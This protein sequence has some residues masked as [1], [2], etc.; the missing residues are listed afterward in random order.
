[1]I[2]LFD[3]L[4]GKAISYSPIKTIATDFFNSID[5]KNSLKFSHIVIHHSATKDGLANDWDAIR[6]WHI[7]KIGSPDP[8]SS[9]YN[10]YA[11][12]PMIDIGYYFG[13]E[14]DDNKYVYR[15][16]RSLSWTGG[17][18][19]GFNGKPNA[20][21]GV[22]CIGNFDSNSLNL[23]QVGMISAL[24]YEICHYYKIPFSNI[25]GHWQSFIILKQVKTKEEA[26]TKYKSCPGKNFDVELIRNEVK[27][28]SYGKTS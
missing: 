4:F 2:Y 1:M 24:C 16:G 25:I 11:A 27:K 21:L 12:A 23:N 8:K 5:K 20:G 15:T 7:G 9:D 22:C 19:L 28:L 6:K 10:K 3:R 26:W 13:L 18:C 14:Y 17:H